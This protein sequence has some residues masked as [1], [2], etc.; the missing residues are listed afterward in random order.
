MAKE[1]NIG[2]DGTA[3]RATDLLFGVDNIA[4]RVVEGYIGV[5][6]IARLFYAAEEI[7]PTPEWYYSGEIEAGET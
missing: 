1:I 5:D 3:R 7:V 6:G 2:V 4:R